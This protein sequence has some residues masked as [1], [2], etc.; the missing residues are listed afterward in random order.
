MSVVMWQAFDRWRVCG[1]LSGYS[2]QLV[3]RLDVRHK[4]FSCVLV[5]RSHLPRQYEVVSHVELYPECTK[6][7]HM[8]N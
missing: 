3:S 7:C 5:I 4:A 6:L 1:L 8:F 2:K